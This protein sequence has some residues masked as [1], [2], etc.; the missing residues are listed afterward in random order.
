[1]INSVTYSSGK[2]QTFKE[3][4]FFGNK[5]VSITTD[6]YTCDITFPVLAI[7]CTKC[8]AV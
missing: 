2:T 1:M 3:V 4:Y 8:H 7:S 6:F 5:Y